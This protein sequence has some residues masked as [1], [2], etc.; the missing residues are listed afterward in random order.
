MEISMS[1]GNMKVKANIFNLPVIKT[2]AKNIKCAAFCYSTKAERVWPGVKK[3]R[4]RNLALSKKNTFVD[5]MVK[6]LKTRKDKI[7]RIHEGGD[8][9]SKEYIQKWY[10]VMSTLPKYS[11]YAYTKQF[12]NFTPSILSEKPVNFTLIASM[13]KDIH[14]YGT[15]NTAKYLE[16]GYDKVAYISKDN[17]NCDN[18][19]DK[20]KKCGPDCDKCI[21]AGETEIIFKL[22]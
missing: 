4:E 12:V 16:M 10:E 11:F 17:T 8:F 9:Y 14:E 21:V 3:S 1:R 19:I 15:G 6:V 20:S 18:Q 7:V 2:C 13:D 22:H 5:S